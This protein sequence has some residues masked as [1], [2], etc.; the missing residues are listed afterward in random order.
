MEDCQLENEMEG[1]GREKETAMRSRRLGRARQ[2]SCCPVGPR[3]FP[4]QQQQQRRR[5]ICF[6]FAGE[7]RYRKA[8][9][10]RNLNLSL[11]CS[12]ATVAIAVASYSLWERAPRP[13]TRRSYR[14]V[15]DSMAARRLHP[16]STWLPLPWPLPLPPCR[17][18]QPP[19]SHSPGDG[20]AVGNGREAV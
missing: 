9:Y 3:L 18:P 12:T 5:Q 11:L 8:S 10:S 1:G 13:L 20:I 16:P 14:Y 7:R 6:G 17:R 2:A 15:E 4:W 19:P